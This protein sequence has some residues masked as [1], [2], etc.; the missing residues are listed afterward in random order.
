MTSVSGINGYRREFTFVLATSYPQRALGLT[1]VTCFTYVFLYRV[2]AFLLLDLILRY[3]KLF[4]Q[5]IARFEVN[6]DATLTDDSE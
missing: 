3:D 6:L 1:N 2:A 4:S 5:S